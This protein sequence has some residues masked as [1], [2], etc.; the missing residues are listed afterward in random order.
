[1]GEAWYRQGEIHRVLGDLGSAEEA[2]REASL[3]GREPQPGHALVRLA[4]NRVDDAAAAIRRATAETSERGIRAGLLPAFVEI[5]L[6]VGDLESAREACVELESIAVDNE[7]DALGA[8]AAHARGALELAAGDPRAALIAARS[9]AQAWQEL[10]APYD[11]ARARE[12]V[13]LACRKLGDGDA[14]ALELEAA[15]ATFERLG[16]EPDLER[17]DALAPA[18]GRNPQGLTDRELEVLRHLSA[19]ATNKAI[20]SE[21]VLSVRTVDRHVSNI[22]TKLGVSSR[23]AA[24]AYAYEHNVL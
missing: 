1:L 17:V 14:A 11:N 6:A 22:F 24:T 4:Q 3:Q 13:G 15:G 5:M 21:L 23:A 19:G 7:S 8:M 10:D 2:Y 20:A 12:V 16:A 18:A 9:A